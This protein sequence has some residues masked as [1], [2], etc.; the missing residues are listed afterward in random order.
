M[1][2]RRERKLH[3]LAKILLVFILVFPAVQLVSLQLQINDLQ[4]ECE[5]LDKEIKRKEL[6]NEE[7]KESLDEGVTD[8]SIAKIARDVLGYASP[9]ERIFIDSSEQ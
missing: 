4:Q 2:R 9:G 1:K 3:P 6:A 7:L 5:E 8:E